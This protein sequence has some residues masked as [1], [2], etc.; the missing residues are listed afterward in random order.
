MTQMAALYARVSSDQQ[1]EHNTIASQTAA[2]LD[3][4]QAHDYS[5]PPQW[6]FEDEG[7]SGN[8]L[9]RPGLE[10]LRDLVAEG[11]IERVLIHG[12]DRLSRNYAY[13]VLL[14]EE[15]GRHGAQVVF[16]KA[17]ADETPEQRLLLQPQGII[18]EYERAQIVERCRRGKRHRAKAGVLN[19]LSAAP[20]GYRYVKKSETAQAYYQVVESEAQV[21]RQ[22]FNRYTVEGQSIRAIVKALNAQQIPTR[23]QKNPWCHATVWYML[24]NPA[25]EGR[26][27]YGKTEPG[28]PTR[29]PNR[30][31]RLKGAYT[32]ASPTKLKRR[33]EEWIPIAVPALV[34]PETFEL[35]QER[36]QLNQRLQIRHTKQPSVLQGLLV[37]AQCGY[38]FY[39]VN[40]PSGG[41]RLYYY[42]CGSELKHPK[43]RVCQ[44]RAIRVDHLDQLVWERI[45]ELLNHPELIAREIERRLQEHRQSSPVEQRRQRVS[46]EAARI[47]Q[48]ADNLLDAYQEGLVDLS[49]LRSRMP[50]LKRRQGALEKELQSLTLQALEHSRLL[51]INDSM[52]KFM[53]QLKHSAQSL[54]V[55]QKQK[56]VRLLV[57]EVV[58][59][60]DS[61]TI[62]HHI[63]LSGHRDGQKSP[64]YP[65]C[66]TRRDG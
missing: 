46:Q 43:G 19:V 62:H 61:I 32:K 20:Y 41:R 28:P 54:N 11:V 65:L 18:A 29:R 45:W 58:V 25:Y 52:D 36:L 33:P 10:R 49:Q 38:A 37:C 3:Y 55:E 60:S 53:Q 59:A 39:R 21:V 30:T 14:L 50:E 64:D 22:M 66:L 1:R 44:A 4:A 9:V 51:E 5:V 15:F 48:Q 2:L 63:P 17:P 24:K 47:T 34:S 7:Y 16:L 12:P 40:S 42:R 23:S 35:A 13:Q 56:I 57:K 8:V 27:C 6:R 26:A 31:R